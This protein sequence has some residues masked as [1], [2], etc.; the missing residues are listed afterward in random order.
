MN[1]AGG[2]S[3]GGG[4]GVLC[5]RERVGSRI[6]MVDYD[7]DWRLSNSQRIFRGSRQVRW[8][9]K[10]EKVERTREL[11]S[12]GGFQRFG[13]AEGMEECGLDAV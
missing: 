2:R 13:W 1:K 3:F 7:R 11:S 4:G 12:S 6:G 8:L 9:W 10:R 5:R